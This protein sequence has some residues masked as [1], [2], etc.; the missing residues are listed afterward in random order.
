MQSYALQPADTSFVY[1]INKINL[2]TGKI[3]TLPYK[4]KV[5]PFRL[6][7]GSF[8]AFMS[9]ICRL[10]L[11]QD[12][13]VASFSDEQTLYQIQQDKL[14]KDMNYQIRPH[15]VV[16]FV[17][18]NIQPPFPSDGLKKPLGTNGFAGDYLFINYLHNDQYYTY[19]ENRETGKTYNASQIIDDV[20]HT[21]GHC[22]I[23]SMNQEGCFVF[24]KGRNEIEGDCGGRIPI[25]NGPVVFI[26]KTK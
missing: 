22:H 21:E 19:L 14:S 2:E 24:I 6:K 26:V 25:T 7:D 18:W 11:Y 23:N 3:T 17:K 13:V 12:E 20:F 9:A 8:G 10:T 4:R 16:P 1:T 15:K 5:E